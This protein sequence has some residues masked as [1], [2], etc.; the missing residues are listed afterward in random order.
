MM[1]IATLQQKIELL[2]EQQRLRLEAYVDYLFETLKQEEL[3]RDNSKSE[4]SIGG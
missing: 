2:S 4:E 3:H 1:E